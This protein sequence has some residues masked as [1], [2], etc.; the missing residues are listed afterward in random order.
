MLT[1]YAFVSDRMADLDYFLFLCKTAFSDL[2]YK[3]NRD[4]VW[5]WEN[6]PE[7]S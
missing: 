3:P 4:P 5:R 2:E 1:G 6:I 7:Y